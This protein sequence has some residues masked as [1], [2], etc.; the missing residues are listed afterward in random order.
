MV[1]ETEVDGEGRRVEV[2]ESV[3]LT[4]EAL[5]TLFWQQFQTTA[6]QT[7]RSQTPENAHL[8]EEKSTQTDVTSLMDPLTSDSAVSF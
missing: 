7:S 1:P 3:P 6:T 4:T 5:E 8:D 2:T